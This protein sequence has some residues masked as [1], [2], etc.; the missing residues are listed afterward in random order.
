[1]C[2]CAY[3]ITASPIMSM[4]LR[5]SV[6]FLIFYTL[7][8]NF[9]TGRG[10]RTLT[11]RHHFGN[12]N[13]VKKLPAAL[14]KKRLILVAVLA[15]VAGFAVF[16]DKGLIDVWRLTNERDGIRTQ[17]R[18]LAKENRRLEAEIARLKTDRRFVTHIA[19]KE[20][21]MIGK[22]E[23]IYRLEDSR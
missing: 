15:V 2:K 14:T 12:P 10:P 17:N 4:F 11:F 19:R 9:V 18:A 16:G 21:G 23:V 6:R 5:R 13:R 22:N 20:L 8:F 1:M 7:F 3:I